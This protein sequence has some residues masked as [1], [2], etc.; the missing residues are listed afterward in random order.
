MVGIEGER[1]REEKGVRESVM[2]W[3]H[4]G[5]KINNHYWIFFYRSLTNAHDTKRF[6]QRQ[7]N[8][9]EQSRTKCVAQLRRNN[10]IRFQ[11]EAIKFILFCVYN[12]SDIF[13]LLDS[14]SMISLTRG[15]LGTIYYCVL[16][17]NFDSQNRHF[18]PRSKYRA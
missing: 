18:D 2:W 5:I 14:S 15:M 6:I 12:F 10:K 9:T 4:G 3:R 17:F 13:L 8:D 11:K 7:S 16:G 1:E